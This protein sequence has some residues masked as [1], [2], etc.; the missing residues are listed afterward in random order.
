MCQYAAEGRR[1]GVEAWHRVH[2]GSLAAGGAGLVVVEATAVAANGR[3]T[4]WDLGLW[5]DSQ[6]AP[7]ASVAELI[8]AQGAIA[9]IQIG[10][11]GRKGSTSRM[12]EGSTP[13]PP[14]A[15]GYR[16]DAPSAVAFTGLPVPHELS[17]PE[18]AA[19]AAA[20]GAAAARAR[21]AGFQAVEIHAAH[22]YLLHQ[23][24]S[25]LANRRSDSYGGSL[26]NRS[27][28]PLDVVAAAREAI[29]DDMA[30]MM[31]VSATDWVDGGW[32]L[33]QTAQLAAWARDAGLD[34]LDVSS[35]GVVAEA[36]VPVGP[37]YQVP[38]AAELGRATGLSVNAVGLIDS[39]AVA[40]QIVAEGG[41]DA[42]MLGRPLLRDPH[43]PIKWATQLGEDPAAWSPP[44]YAIAGWRR[45]HGPS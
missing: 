18:M 34:H 44:Q 42:V 1:G 19:V 41:V 21:S 45:H 23:F 11:A 8:K 7:L 3:I 25:P 2:Y 14:E 24:L 10:H 5:D 32:D 30:L 39:A 6:I 28:L 16:A 4:P 38:L 43:T 12:W 22:G 9:A 15:G 17:W 31:R 33:D 40:E 20:F 13:V 26:A 27:R 35:G 37:A 29:G 36:R